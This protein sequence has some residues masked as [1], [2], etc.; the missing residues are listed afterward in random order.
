MYGT[1][2][3]LAAGLFSGALFFGVAAQSARAQ[4]P[5]P[6]SQADKQE[7][8]VE[9][10]QL[11]QQIYADRERLRADIHRFGPHSSQVQADR[12]QLW[13]DREAQRRLKMDRKRDRRIRRW[14]RHRRDW[15]RDADRD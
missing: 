1:R 9:A 4:D 5:P 14:R 12:E 10:Q 7:D 11:R 13:Q 3:W 8:R 15:H 2:K 6:G